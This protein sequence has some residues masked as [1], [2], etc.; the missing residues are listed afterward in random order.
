[1][2]EKIISGGQTGA[3]V[4]GL[5][6]ARLAGIPTGGTAPKGW[7]IC[8]EDGSDGADPELES[9][10]LVEHESS[11]YP[12]RT[13]KN[14]E[15]SDGTVWFGYT[16]SPGGKLTINTCAKLKKPCLINPRASELK[17]WAE[18]SNIKILNVA[19]NRKSA[20]NPE[21]YDSTFMT[22]Y[23]AFR[24]TEPRPHKVY[25]HYETGENHVVIATG[26]WEIDEE[27][28][29]VTIY[30]SLK[31]RIVWVLL[32][33]EFMEVMEKDGKYCL[34]FQKNVSEQAA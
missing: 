9:F 24:E 5:D 11:E 2:I 4:A 29:P 27:K 12:P 32:T 6:A 16:D 1:V 17:I 20:S 31:T 15:D 28:E 8:L 34:R 23:N 25:Q 3:D 14:I 7:R 13:I 30:Q 19:G 18:E 21:I 22:I 33:A 26:F 10:G